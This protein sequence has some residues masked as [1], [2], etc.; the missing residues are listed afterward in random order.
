ME[1]DRCRAPGQEP[2]QSS[3]MGLTW[4]SKKKRKAGCSCHRDTEGEVSAHLLSDSK[5]ALVWHTSLAHALQVFHKLKDRGVV[6][7]GWADVRGIF[8]FESR[9]GIRCRSL[10]SWAEPRYRAW[11]LGW[12]SPA[13]SFSPIYLFLLLQSLHTACGYSLQFRQIAWSTECI[14][15]GMWWWVSPHPYIKTTS[16]CI[17]DLLPEKAK[18]TDNTLWLSSCLHLHICVFHLLENDLRCAQKWQRCR[19]KN[20]EYSILL[21]P[22][23]IWKIFPLH[24]FQ[25]RRELCIFP[26]LFTSRISKLCSWRS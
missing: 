14:K 26:S 13:M 8:L 19:P 25:E 17:P 24:S 5:C 1:G 20:S 3:S 21:C 16:R 6:G 23:I 2:P 11:S 4:S 18:A 7:I 9:A 15:M 12:A 10:F 22:S